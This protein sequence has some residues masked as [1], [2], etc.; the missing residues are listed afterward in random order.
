MPR[1]LKDAHSA[2]SDRTVNHVT[3]RRDRGFSL[4]ELMAALVVMI[5]LTA[6]SVPIYLRHHMSENEA[7]A[8]SALRTISS[9]QFSFK[10]STL[11]DDDNDGEGGFG[12]MAQLATLEG[13]SQPL[14]DEALAS[15]TW[16][17]YSFTIDVFPG[18]GSLPAAFSARAVPLLE[19]KTGTRRF[20]VD[21]SSVLRYTGDGSTVG[22]ESPLVE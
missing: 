11:E 16:Q 5:V 4:I 22:P 15:G 18:S 6:I 10:S 21:Q 17:G 7:A 13:D 2:N 19:G 1:D 9:A 12:T 8:V 14:I 20:Y 3:S